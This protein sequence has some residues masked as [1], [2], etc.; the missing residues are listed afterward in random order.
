MIRNIPMNMTRRNM[1]RSTVSALGAT[2]LPTAAAQ[3]SPAVHEGNAGALSNLVSLDDFERAARERMAAMAY[4][5]VASGAGDEVTIRWNREDY[6]KLKL[7]PR[8]L[9]DVEVLDTSLELFGQKSDFP[10]LLAPTSLHRLTHPEGE[11]ETARG[12]GAANA[13]FVVSSLSTRRM[14]DIAQAA[15]KPLWFNCMV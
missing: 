15:S 12:A 6:N 2:L 9:V 14:A 3:P 1:V 13:T 10:I 4:E 7:R 5:F 11:V 8:V